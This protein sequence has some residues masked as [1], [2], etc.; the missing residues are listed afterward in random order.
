[1]SL[2]CF[3]SLSFLRA[4]HTANNYIPPSFFPS[5]LDLVIWG[6]EHEAHTTP[7]YQPLTSIKS[8]LGEGEGEGED[9]DLD[10]EGFYIYQPGSS[11]ATS[12]CEG[13]V[14]KK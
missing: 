9:D 6:H 11:V 4:Q 7:E 14:A 1:M 5:F 3:V 12:L 10:D 2:D 13:E 8:L